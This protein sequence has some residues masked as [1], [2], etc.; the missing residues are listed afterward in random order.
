[1]GFL[2]LSANSHQNLKLKA[3]IFRASPTEF[4]VPFAKYQK[5]LYGNQISLGMR[6]RMMFETEELGTR[7]YTLS[8]FTFPCV[9]C[10]DAFLTNIMCFADT[11]NYN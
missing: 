5:A 11:S 2:L 4:V 1:M 8:H 7:R 9:K 10:V 3:F 6:F